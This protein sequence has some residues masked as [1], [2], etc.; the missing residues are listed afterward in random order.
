M[1]SDHSGENPLAQE[2]RDIIDELSALRQQ[3]ACR[4]V[5]CGGAKKIRESAGDQKV[6][7]RAAVLERRINDLYATLRKIDEQ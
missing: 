6:R 1:P 4:A 5:S 7:D 3:S 2:L